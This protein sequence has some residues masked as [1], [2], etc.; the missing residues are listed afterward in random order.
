MRQI[1]R[2]LFYLL[3]QMILAIG[4][5]LS[6]KVNLGVSP[7]LS[8]AY[9]AAVITGRSIGDPYRHTSRYVWYRPSN[10]SFQ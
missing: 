2:V 9:C 5:T 1:R 10:R 7:I 4:L 6:T 3:G 8:I